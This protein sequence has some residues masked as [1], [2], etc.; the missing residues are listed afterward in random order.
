MSIARLDLDQR[1]FELFLAEQNFRYVQYIF[2]IKNSFNNKFKKQIQD[3]SFN[4]AKVD[5]R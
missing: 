5:S 3:I 1:D 2:V 4:S